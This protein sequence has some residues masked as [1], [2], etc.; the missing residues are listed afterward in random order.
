MAD[1]TLKVGTITNSAGS[2]NIT[3][4]SGVTVNVNRP[5]FFAYA[6]AVQ[7]VADSTDTKVNLD[8]ESWDTDSA[9]NTSTYRFTVPTGQAGKYF[10]NGGIGYTSLTDNDES[11]VMIYK[12]GS[13]V[14]W[15][16]YFQGQNGTIAVQNSVI[17]D[18][19]VS[20]YIELYAY[21][22]SGGSKNTASGS[23]NTYLT[24]YKL[25]A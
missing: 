1:G 17:L 24:G 22:V 7:A 6:N 15:W 2:G 9:F 23:I 16:K 25:G 12:N 10:F 11:R 3:I 18:L 5:S 20:D 8:T 4:G 19:A 13:L 14:N 21:Q